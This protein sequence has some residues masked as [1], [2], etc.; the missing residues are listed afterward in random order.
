M[1]PFAGW[2]MPVQYKGVVEEHH[3]VRRGAGIFDVSHMGEIELGGPEA[4]RFVDGLVT[5]AV[6]KIDDGQ[7]QYT[8]A[9]NESGTILD[10]LIV[11]RLGPERVLV[12]CNASNRA[13]IVA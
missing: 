5:N 4:V 3:A 1:V 9:C 7:A 11:Y 2:D 13:K 6:Q 10:D 8:V 12:V